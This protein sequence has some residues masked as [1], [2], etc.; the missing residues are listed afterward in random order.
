TAADHD[1]PQGVHF[2]SDDLAE[3]SAEV[4]GGDAG[5]S[6]A[7]QQPDAVGL[8][9][10]YLDRRRDRTA[11]EE[12]AVGQDLD[13]LGNNVEV[14]VGD[15]A[16]GE[17]RIESPVRVQL[18]HAADY[19]TV[20]AQAEQ[21]APVRAEGDVG[22]PDLGRAGVERYEVRLAADSEGRVERAVRIVADQDA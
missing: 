20:D 4:Q 22:H 6:E 2:H 14:Q 8:N 17:C 7:C 15:A 3:L 11:D 21:D 12:R 13:L 9:P 19:P 16:D 18:G 10:G 1:P 5:Y